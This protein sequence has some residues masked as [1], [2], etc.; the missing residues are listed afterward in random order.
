MGLGGADHVLRDGIVRV[1]KL[2]AAVRVVDDL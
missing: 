1:L 2:L